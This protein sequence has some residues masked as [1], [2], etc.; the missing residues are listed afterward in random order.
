MFR[1][2]V[3]YCMLGVLV[4]CSGQAGNVPSPCPVT[5]NPT[6]INL[7]ELSGSQE[8]A[9]FSFE[10][11]NSSS[12]SVKAHIQPGC[13]CTVVEQADVEIEGGGSLRVPV[14]FSLRGRTGHQENVIHVSCRQD[15]EVW[16]IDIAVKAEVLDEWSSSPLRVVISPK[17]QATV[18]VNSS[19]TEWRNVESC[20]VGDGFVF[21]DL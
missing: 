6:E 21:H 14:T 10:I 16:P 2:S 7:G 8:V 5:L 11:A 4:G 17:G 12:A 1:L 20:A 9:E 19:A 13:G 18:T 15:D 3:C